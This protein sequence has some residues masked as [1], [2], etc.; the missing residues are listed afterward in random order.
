MMNDLLLRLFLIKIYSFKA[1]T[2]SNYYNQI[3][4]IEMTLHKLIIQ[5]RII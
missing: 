2:W 1:N 3:I 5:I 4:S